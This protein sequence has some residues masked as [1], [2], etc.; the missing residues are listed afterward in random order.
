MSDDNLHTIY[1]NI[2][3][4]SKIDINCV[5]KK[6]KLIKNR[7]NISWGDF[8]QVRAT[9]NSIVEIEKQEKNYG[10]LIFISAMHFPILCNY[11]IYNKIYKDKEY[12]SYT[13][14]SSDGWEGAMIRYQYLWFRNIYV[15]KIFKYIFNLLGYRR[16]MIFDY[17]PYGGSQWFILS[18]RCI[19]YIV[20]FLKNNNSY[21]C[22]F[23]YVQC[24]DEI[25]FQTLIMNSEFKKNVINSNLLYIDWSDCAKGITSSPNTLT[26]KDYDKIIYSENIFCRKV[27]L[28]ESESLIRKLREKIDEHN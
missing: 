10:H 6:S 17:V 22:F 16:K 15:S 14:L 4:K 20:D 27:R 9:I 21:N 24:A 5:S 26:I 23:K 11:E 25:F 18:R 12:L 7:T 28:P 13:V 3:L 1:T 2:D 19:S 8:S